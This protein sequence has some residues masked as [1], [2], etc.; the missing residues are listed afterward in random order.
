MLTLSRTF[1]HLLRKRF[2]SCRKERRKNEMTRVVTIVFATTRHFYLS[3]RLFLRISRIYFI[4]RRRSIKR[5]Q[6]VDWYTPAKNSSRKIS[7]YIYRFYIPIFNKS[8]LLKSRRKYAISHL[9]SIVCVEKLH[10]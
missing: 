9:N 4:L 8:K 2:C 5:S 10:F 3:A 6:T 7:K 1:S